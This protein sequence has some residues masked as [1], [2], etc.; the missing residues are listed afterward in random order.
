LPSGTTRESVFVSL[1]TRF[2]YY[3]C[4][5]P[6]LEPTQHRTQCVW[7]SLVYFT[8]IMYMNLVKSVRKL[9][10]HLSKKDKI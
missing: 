8:L 10:L 9:A 4:L 1:R 6:T 5:L 7:G 2:L 3:S